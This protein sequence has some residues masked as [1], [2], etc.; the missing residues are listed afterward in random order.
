[1]ADWPPDD[2]GVPWASAP[3]AAGGALTAS[4]IALG[5]AGAS[6]TLLLAVARGARPIVRLTN[7][8]FADDGPASS[9]RPMFQ[10]RCSTNPGASAAA[11]RLSC[12]NLPIGRS[13]PP[14]DD[15]ILFGRFAECLNSHEVR[16]LNMLVKCGKS[17]GVAV[18][19]LHAARS[20]PRTPHL[21]AS[22]HAHA[23]TPTHSTRTRR[24]LMQSAPS[25]CVGRK[26]L[27]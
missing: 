7:S 23:L 15:A 13:V 18:S 1:M 19:T 9:S 17:R 2:D 26:T 16:V 22:Y 27:V 3:P 5:E 24:S 20:C 10:G 21:H 14:P 25:L 6:T 11:A 8:D 4:L 12:D